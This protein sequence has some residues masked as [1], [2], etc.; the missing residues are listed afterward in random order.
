[1]DVEDEDSEF[2]FPPDWSAPV[3]DWV[4]PRFEAA[5]IFLHPFFRVPEDLCIY[6]EKEGYRWL[7]PGGY[8]K[9]MLSPVIHITWA[10]VMRDLK[11]SSYSL[12]NDTINGHAIGSFALKTASPDDVTK[13]DTYLRTNSI[14]SPQTHYLPTTLKPQIRE[15]LEK[16]GAGDPIWSESFYERGNLMYATP[17]ECAFS[18]ICGTSKLLETIV[19]TYGFEGFFAEADTK[20][21]W[22]EGANHESGANTGALSWKVNNKKK[23][24]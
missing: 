3:L 1:M 18:F 6:I 11:I 5:Y 7:E 24:G 15:S 19:Q 23:K 8:E 22:T 4:R 2:R 13:L 16:F 20:F 17:Y 12:L 21:D 10:H 9:L 14:V